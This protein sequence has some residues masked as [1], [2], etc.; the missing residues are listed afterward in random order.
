M[1]VLGFAATAAADAQRQYVV[2]VELLLP[3]NLPAFL[4]NLIRPATYSTDGASVA[5][6]LSQGHLFKHSSNALLR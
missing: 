6:L 5:A 1:V 4:C 2:M 3:A